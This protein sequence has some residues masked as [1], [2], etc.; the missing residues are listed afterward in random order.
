MIEGMETSAHAPPALPPTFFEAL[1]FW[2]KLGFISFGGPT[3]QIAIMHQ[4][5][6]EKRRWISE[7][8]FSHALNFCML[9]PGP[10]AQQL[11]TY[12]GWLLHGISG[13]LAAGL[14]FIAPAVV[15]LWLLSLLYVTFG[16]LP[17]LTGVFLGLKAAVL[18]IVLVALLRI[19]SRTLKSKQSYLIAVCAFAALFWDKV[20][21]PLIIF[22]AAVAGY[23]QWTFVSQRSGAP[24]PSLMCYAL[25]PLSSTIKKLLFGLVIWW[26]PLFLAVQALGYDHA[27]SKEG[28]FFSKAA[29][30]TFGGAYAVLP[31]VSQQ[32]VEHFHWLSQAQMIDGLGL[33]ET[34]P[35]PLIMVLQ[36][37]G[38]L[39]A[40]QN[41][42]NLTPLLSATTGALVTT[43]ATFVPCFI[44]IF[45]GAPYVEIVRQK[46]AVSAALSCVTAAVVGVIANLGVWMGRHILFAEDF[47][48]QPAAVTFFL[49]ALLALTR[50]RINMVLVIVACGVAGFACGL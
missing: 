7:E 9:L 23:L 44:F 14:L 8:Q 30:I 47:S 35:G 48:P 24:A 50:L 39:G 38:F 36:F 21:F 25:P 10:E 40:Y 3:G 12:I 29:L 27:I 18:A 5:I 34:T 46:R 4:E 37:V 41:P 20:S 1:G 26:A 22:S 11:A 42:G 17:T 19:A 13:G 16:T 28:F 31:Y 49:L 15:L 2:T 45:V 32:A 33:A 43:W 6:V